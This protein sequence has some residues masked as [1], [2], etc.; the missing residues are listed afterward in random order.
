[1]EVFFV[2]AA[3]AV[4]I[5]KKLDNITTARDIKKGDLVM[6]ELYIH[7]LNQWVFDQAPRK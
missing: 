4:S 6:M 3:W 1:M 7:Y 5:A 2:G